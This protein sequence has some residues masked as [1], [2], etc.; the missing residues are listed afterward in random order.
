MAHDHAAGRAQ[1]SEVQL[2]GRRTLRRASV[3]STL[4]ASADFT[5]AQ[6]L[7][8][9]L[10]STGERVGLSTVYRTLAAL[11]DAGRA[12]VVRD[13]GGERVW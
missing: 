5:S 4:I 3:L 9:R 13:P 11:A 12:D 1:S 7:H 8:A 2:I 10:R 6:T